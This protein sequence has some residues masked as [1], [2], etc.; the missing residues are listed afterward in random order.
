M[1]IYKYFYENVYDNKI[2]IKHRLKNIYFKRIKNISVKVKI[3]L[4]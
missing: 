2:L 3:K 1:S 4:S